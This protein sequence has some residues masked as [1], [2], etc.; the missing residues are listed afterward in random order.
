M[1]EPELDIA[2]SVTSIAGFANALGGLHPATVTS[3]GPVFGLSAAPA[4]CVAPGSLRR[5]LVLS[6]CPSIVTWARWAATPC[7][8]RFQDAAD[9][10]ALV[11]RDDAL[12]VLFLSTPNGDR[13]DVYWVAGSLASSP[14][15]PYG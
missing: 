7:D 11:Q 1:D 6:G 9:G 2:R 12:G 5:A 13:G 3:T 14:R 10:F 8:H 4:A 15:L